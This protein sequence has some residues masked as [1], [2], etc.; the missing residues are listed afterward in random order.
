[1]DNIFNEKE[2][3]TK[4]LGVL[5]DENLS[6]KQYINDVSTKYIKMHW[7]PLQIYRNIKTTFIKIVVFFF[8]SLPFELCKYCM[9]KHL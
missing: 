4:F 7:Y 3:I 9:A 8:Y 2:N 1:M 6:W 5:I